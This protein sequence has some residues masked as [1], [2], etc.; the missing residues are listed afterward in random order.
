MPMSLR[1]KLLAAAGKITAVAALT[2]L[3]G[4]G[5][6]AGAQNE[7]P[8]TIRQPPDGA[9]VREK[10]AVKVPLASIAEGAYVAY[11][12]DGQF[13][14]AL[15]PSAEQREKAKAGDMFVYEW[16]TKALYKTRGSVKDLPV[17]EGQHTLAARLYSP[18]KQGASILKETSSVKVNVQNKY[19][20]PSSEP[21]KLRY[22]FRDGDSK[23]YTRTGSTAIVAGLTQGAGGSEDQEMIAQNSELLVAVEDKYTNGDAI[24]RNLLKKL[25]VRQ[26]GQETTYPPDSLPK[27]LYQELDPW[28]NVKYQNHTVSFDEFAQQGIPVSATLELPILPRQNVAVGDKWQSQNVSLDLPGTPPDK[29]PKVLATSTF[30]GIEWQGGYPTAKIHQRYD[31]STGLKLKTITVGSIEVLNPQITFD[32]DIYLAFRSGTLVKV[33]RNLEITGKTL[34]SV[35]TPGPG[36]AGSIGGG[37]PGGGEGMMMGG[38]PGMMG[39]RGGMMGMPGMPGAGRGKGGGEY[40]GGMGMQGA[41]GRGRGGMSGMGGMGAM[42]GSGG[43]GRSGAGGMGIPGMGGPGMGSGASGYPGMGGMMGGMGGVTGQQ[44]TQIK[45]KSTTVTELKTQ[46][47]KAG[48]FNGPK[49]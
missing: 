21:I 48:S 20:T 24:V 46:A 43:R 39:G 16:D 8:F 23:D 40:T 11:Y 9:T 33:V 6:R 18:V 1:E 7:A 17:A 13:R 44:P 12:V 2:V 38:G 36:G 47:P 26:G 35:Q 15:S 25:S 22:Q 28:G 27:A 32:Q 41:G 45:L 10:V 29:Q 37:T 5:Q 31:G 30:E 42:P 14:V 34:Q 4:Y 49:R 19:P 3:C